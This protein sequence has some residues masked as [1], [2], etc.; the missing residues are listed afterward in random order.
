MYNLCA[1]PCT[2]ESTKKF[3]KQPLLCGGS[4]TSIW[5]DKK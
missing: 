4:T 1:L 3:K 2:G 5:L